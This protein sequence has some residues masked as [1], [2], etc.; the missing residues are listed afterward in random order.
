MELADFS[1]PGYWFLATII[2]FLIVV[3]RYFLIA[4]LFHVVFYVWF[5][6]RWRQRKINIKKYKKEQFKKEIGWSMLTAAL[7]AVAGSITLVLWQQGYTKVY[8]EVKDYPMWWLPASLCISMLLHETYYYWLHRWMHQPAIFR[9]VHKVHHDSNITSPWT[10][11]SFHPFERTAAGVVFTIAVAG[12][13]D[14]LVCTPYTAYH[15]DL[16]FGHQSPGYRDLS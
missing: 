4:G 6:Q 13:A 14:A 9:I 2:F 5:P 3:G 15:Y 12:A 7:F 11:F 1:R 8:L 16:Q 10:A